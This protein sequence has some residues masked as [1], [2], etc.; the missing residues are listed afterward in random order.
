MIVSTRLAPSLIVVTSFTS[1]LDNLRAAGAP[2]ADPHFLALEFILSIFSPRAL[3]QGFLFVFILVW[4]L[5]LVS[6]FVLLF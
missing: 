5:S 1:R 2:S 3:L 4:L 6:L